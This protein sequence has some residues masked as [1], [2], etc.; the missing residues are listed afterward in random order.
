ML[1]VE[2]VLMRYDDL[3]KGYKSFYS[4]CGKCNQLSCGIMT[5]FNA[6]NFRFSISFGNEFYDWGKF[7]GNPVRVFA[8]RDVVNEQEWIKENGVS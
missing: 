1:A 3:E 5:N 8:E 4:F 2:I 6:A 7:L